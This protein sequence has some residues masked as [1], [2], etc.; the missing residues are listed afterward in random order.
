MT[1]SHLRRITDPIS[2]VPSTASQ[3]RHF[4]EGIYDL[5]PESHL[6]RF[7][8]ALLGDSGVGYLSKIYVYAQQQSVLATMRYADLDAFYGSV[9]GVNRFSWERTD[10]ERYFLANTPEEWDEID[11]RDASYRARIDSFSR[12][13][14]MGGT[15]SGLVGIAEALLGVECRI[16]ESYLTIDESGADAPPLTPLGN[17]TYGQ[18]EEVFPRYQNMEKMLYGD[19]E[20]GV[21]T[22]GRSE[23]SDRAHFTIRPMRNISL[24]ERYV[25][26]KVLDRFKPVGSLMSI[27]PEGAALHKVAK[28]R[29]VSSES[30]HWEVITRAYPVNTKGPLYEPEGADDPGSGREPDG[31]GYDLKRPAQ[32]GYQGEVWSY[33]NDV[34]HVR[35]YREIREDIWFMLPD[36]TSYKQRITPPPEMPHKTH[37]P[38]LEVNY[39]R[40]H[41]AT[42][43]RDYH[44]AKGMADHITLML[45][46]V[47]SDG[48]NAA[49]PM[50][51]APTVVEQV[52][53]KPKPPV[54][55]QPK[56]GV[57][58]RP[59][60]IPKIP[61]IKREGPI[62]INPINPIPPRPPRYGID[63]WRGETH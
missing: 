39:E 46:R 41:Y 19:I 33:N 61:P 58:G 36:P 38:G 35:G 29:G 60:L 5:S 56:P 27:N 26:T 10:V 18:V 57:P 12:A 43:P 52:K 31:Q 23:V 63:P 17:R 62:R 16:Y 8:K 13:I 9:L 55:V 30:V 7:V 22:I 42:G 50:I 1:S 34:V 2:V 24:E 40:V 59:I 47:A 14:A 3:M 51:T 53:P 4:F 49:S 54:R 44:P 6:T 32:S 20:A 21:G 11:A 45:G 15:P 28:I 48:V 25:L 37:T